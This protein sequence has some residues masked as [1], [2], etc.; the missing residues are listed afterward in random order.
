MFVEKKL[1]QKNFQIHLKILFVK[2]YLVL[3]EMEK[4]EETE[5][6]GVHIK[7][8]LAWMKKKIA[9]ETHQ[10]ADILENLALMEK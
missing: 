4:K 9:Q 7:E 6:L 3:I 1:L 8:Q 10:E 2:T 5:N